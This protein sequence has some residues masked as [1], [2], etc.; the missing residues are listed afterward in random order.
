MHNLGIKQKFSIINGVALFL[1]ISFALFPIFWMLSSSF[2]PHPEFNLPEPVWITSNPTFDNFIAIFMSNEN[3]LGMMDTSSWRSIISSIVVATVATAISISIGFLAAVGIAR[4]RVGG[5]II[6]LQILMF[7]M[8]PPIA[9]AIPFGIIGHILGGASAPVLLIVIYIVYTIPLST[10]MLKSFIE[11]IPPEIEDAA[12][13]DGMSRWKAHFK[14]TLPLIKGGLAATTMFIFI[15][16][17]SEGT[18]AM[19]LATGQWVTIPVDIAQRHYAPHIQ[20]ALG[21]I[22]ATPL[23]IGGLLIHKHLSRGFTFGAIKG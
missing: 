19:S 12:L 16:N 1:A 2:K 3:Q 17:W 22:G 23:I 7:R 18:I 14:I 20:V 10:W 8:V 11:Q 4:Y 5:N 15:V 21:V 6:P 13:M 9:V